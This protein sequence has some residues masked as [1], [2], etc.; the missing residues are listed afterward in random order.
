MSAATVPPPPP[1]PSISVEALEKLS[2]KELR[3]RANDY[4]AQLATCGHEQEPAVLAKAQFYLRQLEHRWDSR[5]ST[6]DLILEII[7]ILLIGGEIYMGIRQ[8][9]H[10]RAN[11]NDQQ[12]VLKNMLTSSQKTADTLTALKSTTEV[13]N[14]AVK[15][16]AA[17]TEA[18][19]VTS[20]Q[21]LHMS[22]RAYLAATVS[23]PTPP[24]AGDKIHV[25]VSIANAGKGLAIDVVTGSRLVIVPKDTTPENALAFAISTMP[26]PQSAASKTPI[27]AGQQTQQILDSP[28]PLTEDEVKNIENQN[29]VIYT[30]VDATYKDLFGRAHRFQLCS[31]YYPPTK[32]T[33][34]CS[35]LNKAD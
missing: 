6:R 25:I 28:R 31:F 3:K 1:E 7:V 21:T 35:T 18:N 9:G 29:N 19:A 15:R 30:F 2:K 24:K 12:G 22:E 5:I 32:Q 11:F 17:A 33:A 10:Q 4:F 13:M 23:M 26:A 27:V 16:S 14:E 20:A 34:S 8:E